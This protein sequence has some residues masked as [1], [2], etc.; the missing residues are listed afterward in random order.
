MEI[1]K[2]ELVVEE[3]I[4]Y[5]VEVILEENR[6]SVDVCLSEKP[7]Q[8]VFHIGRIDD[9]IYVG[10]KTDASHFNVDVFDLSEW[11]ELFLPIRSMSAATSLYDGD[12]SLFMLDV[13]AGKDFD[14]GN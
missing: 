9:F 3:I 6:W 8:D 1:N 5:L 4:Q 7:I 2:V 13:S 10:Y 11:S 14:D 12:I